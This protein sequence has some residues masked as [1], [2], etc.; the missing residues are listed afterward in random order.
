[1]R[2]V[3]CDENRILSEA[4]ATAMEALGHEVVAIT[5][6]PEEGLAAPL[7]S[8]GTAANSPT[9]SPHQVTASVGAKHAAAGRA[10][11]SLSAKP[12]KR[13][14]TAAQWLCDR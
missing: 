13:R 4:L 5:T 10:P 1:M 7:P 12:R 2:L 8:T 9:N 11:R 14:R 3:F 6:S